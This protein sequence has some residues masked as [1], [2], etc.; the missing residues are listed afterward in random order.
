MQLY[1]DSDAT[2]LGL[3]NARSRGAG[4]FYLS[5]KLKNTTIM[6]VPKMNRLILTECQVLN[7]YMSS[8]GEA[9][10]GTINKSGKA[11]IPI[12]VALDELVHK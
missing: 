4:Y 7:K 9:E 11:A 1:I 8:T 6:Q 12:K 5:E 10:A 3:P 2:C